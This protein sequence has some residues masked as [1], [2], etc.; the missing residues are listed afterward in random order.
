MGL[1]QTIRTVHKEKEQRKL[2]DSSVACGDLPCLLYSLFY[3]E[4]LNRDREVCKK[5]K[6]KILG[7]MAGTCF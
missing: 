7:N 1:T 5:K 6:K 2:F 3:K 4:T